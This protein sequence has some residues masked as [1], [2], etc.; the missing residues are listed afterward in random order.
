MSAW[1]L[2][3]GQSYHDGGSPDSAGG[4]SVKPLDL[5]MHRPHAEPYLATSAAVARRP[6][7]G[8]SMQK[9]K[10]KTPSLNREALRRLEPRDLSGV[11]GGFSP[12]PPTDADLRIIPPG[13]ITGVQYW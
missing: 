3:T 9:K 1:L 2:M 6:C 7:K 5:V 12:P 13:A 8:E 10:P 11:A 4:G